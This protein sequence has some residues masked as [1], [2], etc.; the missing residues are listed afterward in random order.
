MIFLLIIEN[1]VQDVKIRLYD[2][3]MKTLISTMKSYDDDDS[4]GRI[5]SVKFN[6]ENSNNYMKIYLK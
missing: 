5:F 1:F 3:E 6:P 4:T 2:E